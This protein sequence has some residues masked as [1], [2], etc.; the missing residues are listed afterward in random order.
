[1]KTKPWLLIIFIFSFS[2]LYAQKDE[3]EIQLFIADLIEQYTA[4]AP[5]NIDLTTFYDNL[6]YCAHHPIHINQANR[7]DL[8]KLTFLS[9]TQVENILAYIYL[10][11]GLKTIY[12]LRLIDGLDMTDI[13]R[14][15]GFITLEDKEPFFKE[16]KLDKLIKYGKN[17]IIMSGWQGAETKQGYTSQATSPYLGSAW[18]NTFRYRFTSRNRLLAGY[19]ASKDAGEQFWGTMNKG[20]DYNSAYAQLNDLGKIQKVIV[21]DFQASFGQGL[22]LHPSF[23]IGRS[24]YVLNVTPRS[25]GFTK[26]GSTAESNFFRGIA[27]SAKFGNVT[28]STFYSNRYIDADTA[29]GKFSSTYKTGYHRT[30]SEWRKKETVNQQVIGGDVTLNFSKLEV[31]TTAVHTRFNQELSPDRSVYNYFYFSGR[32]QSTLGVHYRGLWHNVSFF[33]ETALTDQQALATING[34]SFSPISTVSLVALNRY[35]SPQYYSFYA[36]AFAQS[37]KIND[38]SGTYLGV[39]VHPAAKWMIRAYA[40]SY[41]FQWPKYFISS[42]SD[43]AELLLQTD[44]TSSKTTS[45]YWRIKYETEMK[46]YSALSSIMPTVLPYKRISLRYNLNSRYD[47][48]TFK[49]VIEGNL[50]QIDQQP[51]TYGS[52]AYQDISISFPHPQ[53]TINLRL[54]AFD[55][56]NYNNRVYA[57]EQDILYAFSIPM[58]YGIG[59][60]YYINLKYQLSKQLSLWMK[61]AQTC[62]S[63]GREYI[64]SGNETV[65]GNR[66]TDIKMMMKYVF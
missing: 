10:N 43:G 9:D 22:V 55:A 59:T 23:S 14:M 6:M 40:D 46:D 44:Y 60:R 16:I 37:S 64:G 57:Y 36:T 26:H 21:G 33:G 39:E 1:V 62:Y 28:I 35:Y 31:G 25:V 4:E 11:G 30:E 48:L 3:N 32:S 53:L 24:S 50:V 17:E 52:T 12:E 45:M 54:Q 47:Q 15:L 58:F 65:K 2:T 27:T 63:D 8:E 7:Q 56:V 41:K 49:T 5:E 13:R 19:T 66:D 34:L 61:I 38:E 51:M 42:P 20:F 18:A 29:N